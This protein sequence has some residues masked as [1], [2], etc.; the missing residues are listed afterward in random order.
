MNNHDLFVLEVLAATRAMLNSSHYDDMYDDMF[1][2]KNTAFELRRA[3]AFN[4]NYIRVSKNRE[5]EAEE[6][7]KRHASSLAHAIE[8]QNSQRGIKARCECTL[9][10]VESPF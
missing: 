1:N 4:S 8:R 9:E 7:S 5:Y 3:R 6:S 2:R 10:T